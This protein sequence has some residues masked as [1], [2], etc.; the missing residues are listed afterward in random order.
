MT[1]RPCFA[2][3]SA[4]S[5]SNTASPIAA[6]GDAGR[7]FATTVTAA[8]GSTI[9][10]N[11]WSKSWGGTRCTA[12]SGVIRRSSTNSTA[13]RTAASPVRC[14]RRVCSM[15]SLPRSKVNSM[16]CT[17]LKCR[18]SLAAMRSSSPYTFASAPRFILAIGSGV[19]APDTTSSPCAFRRKSPFSTFSPVRQ[20]R[21]KATPVPESSPMLP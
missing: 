13:I 5:A 3:A 4:S 12:S 7:P 11:S 1:L 9:G 2:K 10:W 16:S 14:A 19:R 6:P 17:S 8:S 21:V 18:S 15:Y 20:S